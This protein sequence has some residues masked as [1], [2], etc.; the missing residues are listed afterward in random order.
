MHRY[1]G[2]R[3]DDF[4]DWWAWPTWDDPSRWYALARRM[5]FNLDKADAEDGKALRSLM[6]AVNQR[7]A[8]E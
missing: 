2:L 4:V 7:D 5:K 1:V 8:E 6:R 3:A